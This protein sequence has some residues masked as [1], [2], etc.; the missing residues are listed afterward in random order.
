MLRL[1]ST[2]EHQLPQMAVWHPPWVEEQSLWMFQGDP[3]LQT[4]NTPRP[5]ELSKG[6][7]QIIHIKLLSQIAS[8]L[9]KGTISR[10]LIL[11]RQNTDWK[12]LLFIF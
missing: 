6:P 5:D 3:C 10:S 4:T 12:L 8:H 2:S 7:A 11:Q 9:L 1:Q